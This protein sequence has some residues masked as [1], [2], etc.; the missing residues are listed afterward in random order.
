M[1]MMRN[2]YG[3]TSCGGS[4][5][6]NIAARKRKQDEMYGVCN[7]DS[8][9][10]NEDHSSESDCVA[11][12]MNNPYAEYGGPSVSGL[13]QTDTDVNEMYARAN[14]EQ[15]NI[16]ERAGRHEE[17]ARMRNIAQAFRS[18]GQKAA[19]RLLWKD[20]EAQA[21]QAGDHARAAYCAQKAREFE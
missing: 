8:G 7:V 9:A 6:A 17:A 14:E 21:L 11:S 4:Y 20:S 12:P 2:P 15:A 13:R 18:G 19:M 10:D 1:G 5:A 16:A 3:W